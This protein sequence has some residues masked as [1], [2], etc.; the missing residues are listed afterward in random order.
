MEQGM[1]PGQPVALVTGVGRASGI[2]FEVC[3]QLAQRGFQVVLSARTAAKAEPLA[4]ALR[5][6]QLAV[7]ALAL[8]LTDGG[9]RR[10]AGAWLSERF[11]ALDVLVNNAAGI[12]RMGET[13]LGANLDDARAV[14][15]TSLFG[16]WALLQELLPL[17][18]RSAHPRIVNVSSGAGS[19]GDP[20]FGLATRNGMGPAY[21]TA[22]AALNALT[23]ALATELGGTHVLVNAVCPGFT[24]TF[25]GA[26]GLG[27]RPVRDGAASVVWAALLPDGGPSGGFFR[28]GRP[29]AW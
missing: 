4:A 27:A 21:A 29:L 16:T 17:L 23:S 13:V 14:F 8:E 26:E 3:R 1:A 18:K 12:G 9:S 2:G 6:E 19:H 7:T 10:A 24:A 15:E 5:A 22:K 11:P 20:A 25:P 28:D